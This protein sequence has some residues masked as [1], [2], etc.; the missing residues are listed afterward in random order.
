[1]AAVPRDP[2]LVRAEEALRRVEQRQQPRTTTPTVTARPP[3]A[4]APEAQ[5]L[6]RAQQLREE[7][8]RRGRTTTPTV[9]LPA[10]G[11]FGVRLRGGSPFDWDD[12]A[13]TPVLE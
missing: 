10:Q 3:L 6:A 4:A 11:G 1:M 5:R 2:R 12:W 7:V 8:R 13:V 9:T